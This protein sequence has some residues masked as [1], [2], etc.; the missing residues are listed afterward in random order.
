VPPPLTLGALVAADAAIACFDAKY[1]YSF[2]RPY[3]AIRGADTDGN[4]AT[5]PDPVWTPLLP[6]PNH[7]EYP[8]AHTCVSAADA[9]VYADLLGTRNINLSL[10]SPATGTTH[11]YRTVEDLI[12]EVINAR[13]WGGIH[14]RN[15]GEVGEQLFARSPCG[16]GRLISRHRGAREASV[17]G[18]DESFDAGAV[19]LA[20][21]G[22]EADAAAAA[23]LAERLVHVDGGSSGGVAA[24]R[25]GPIVES[26]DLLQLCA[27]RPVS[28]RVRWCRR[29]QRPVGAGGLLPLGG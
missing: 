26:G 22:R 16:E 17:G 12:S 29:G 1:H 11:Q 21:D 15:S 23:F 3:T 27:G 5:T 20:A 10:T 14:Y 8:A 4:P 13:V 2:W 19:D 6:T 25:D 9:V 24:G 7:P 28:G 18:C